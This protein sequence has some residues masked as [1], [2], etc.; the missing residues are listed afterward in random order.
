MIE[1]SHIEFIKLSVIAAFVWG[2]YLLGNEMKLYG[3]G[4][5]SLAENLER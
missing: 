3:K 5:N 1:L 2:L 4:A